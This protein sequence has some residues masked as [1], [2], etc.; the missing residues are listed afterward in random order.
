MSAPTQSF[1]KEVAP[2]SLLAFG[3][4]DAASVL[5]MANV[6]NHGSKI[7]LLVFILQTIST[8][9]FAAERRHCAC[10]G[11]EADC[12]RTVQVSQCCCIDDYGPGSELGLAQSRI[13]L[14]PDSHQAFAL[15]PP[16]V[17]ALLA[18][19]SSR[20]LDVSP[21][22]RSPDLPILHATLRL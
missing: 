5:V 9:V 19:A 8:P 16:A 11:G 7:A 21:P 14:F 6:R 2:N 20:Y 12:H 10:P 3:T 18:S 4:P 13:D 17:D 15:L 22:G 1:I